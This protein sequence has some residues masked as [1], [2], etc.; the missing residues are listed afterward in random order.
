LVVKQGAIIPMRR[1]A[2]SIEKGNNNTLTLHVYPGANGSFNLLE[3]DGTSNDYLKG[4][5]SSTI[6]ELK[7]STNNFA[8]TINPV[9]GNYKGMNLYRKWILAI[10]T[11]KAPK[12]ITMNKQ[13]LPFKFDKEKKIAKVESLQATVNKVQNFEVQY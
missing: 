12:K 11:A 13:N 8:L 9:K 2:S 3:D 1:Y 7:N 4:I 10:H 5:Y 6:I